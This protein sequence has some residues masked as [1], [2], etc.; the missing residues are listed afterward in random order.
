MAFSYTLIFKSSSSFTKPLGSV[1]SAPIKIGITVTFMFFS[2]L[3]IFYFFDYL[4]I[5]SFSFIFTL[6]S[7]RTAKSTIRQ[8]FSFLLT[9]T[10]SGRQANVRWSVCIKRSQRIFLD[11]FWV[12]H[13]PPVHMVEFQFFAQF[14]VDHLPHLVV[15]GLM[16]FLVVICY[17]RWSRD[18]SF[19]LYHPHLQFY[20]VLWYLSLP[21]TRQDLKQGQKPEGRLKWG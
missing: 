10:W 12:V 18:Q 11:G 19:R 7:T 17:F 5:F 3:S 15:Y 14:S 16:F 9:I 13:I 20:C 8:V 1:P 21:P 6:W 4:S 2:Y